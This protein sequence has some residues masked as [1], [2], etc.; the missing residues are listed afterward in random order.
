MNMNNYEG[1]SII[2][3][4]EIQNILISYRIG[5][6]PLAKLLGWGETTIIRY[7]EGDIP[8]CEYS[9]KLKAILDSP[10][11][12][13]ELLLKGKDNLT[14]VAY[15]KSRQA[16]LDKIME[17]KINV[18]AQF[19]INRCDAEIDAGEVVYLLYYAQC[20]E[21]AFYGKEL[22]SNEYMIV[23]EST[24]PYPEFYRSLKNRVI[25]PLELNKNLLN[26]KEREILSSVMEAFRWYGSTTIKAMISFERTMMRVSR[27]KDNQRVI[28]KSML[29]SYFENI[30]EN[31][32]MKEPRDIEKYPDRRIVD[33][34]NLNI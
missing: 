24:F 29:K 25:V 33:L 7:I 34:R 1:N 30:I 28:S 18:A 5:K 31:Y 2:T 23:S 4:E 19:L 32:G 14:G 8:T 17:S 10:S 20:F 15:K 26:E 27:D 9:D 6:K 16:V 21:L 13:Y 11:Y 12:Y 3:M 22:F